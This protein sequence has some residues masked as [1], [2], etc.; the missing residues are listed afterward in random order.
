MNEWIDGWMNQ[1]K[2]E[3]NLILYKMV[4]YL[5]NML[6][7]FHKMFYNSNSWFSWKQINCMTNEINIKWK[8][9][10]WNFILKNKIQNNLQI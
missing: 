6:D 4:Y 3:W 8:Q 2:H 5:T 10:A 7:K 9:Y 1:W